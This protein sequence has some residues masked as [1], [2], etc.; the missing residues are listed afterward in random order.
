VVA[1]EDARRIACEVGRSPD[2]Q[3]LLHG[4]DARE[5]VLDQAPGGGGFDA[6][7]L[8]V[9]GLGGGAELAAPLLEGGVD[10]GLLA[11]NDVGEHLGEGGEGDDRFA[12]ALGPVGE[13]LAQGGGVKQ[14]AQ[15]QLG[16]GGDGPFA[17]EQ[18]EQ[19]ILEEVDAHRSPPEQQPTVWRRTPDRLIR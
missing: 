11:Q 13:D 15:G 19:R 2:A 5:G 8:A 10:A 1:V 3:G 17:G 4:R 6:L 7:E 18:A 14:V 12:L 9:H 16:H